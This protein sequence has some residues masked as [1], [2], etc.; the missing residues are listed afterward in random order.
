MTATL[1]PRPLFPHDLGQ[2]GD[3]GTAVARVLPGNA[4][5]RDRTGVEA[6]AEADYVPG[7]STT[8]SVEAGNQRF[9]VKGDDLPLLCTR[10][11]AHS[12]NGSSSAIGGSPRRGRDQYRCPHRNRSGTGRSTACSGTGWSENRIGDRPSGAPIFRN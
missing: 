10:I 9:V 12:M 11:R 5:R 2:P 1:C 6:S 7:G 3:Q 8:R 4:H